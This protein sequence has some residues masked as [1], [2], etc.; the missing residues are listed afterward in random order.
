MISVTL[1]SRADCHL[2]EQALQDLEDLKQEY[3]HRLTVIDVDSDPKLAKEFGFEV[4]VVTVEP[5]RLKAPF[6]VQELKITL[7]AAQDRERHIR[8][9]ESSPKLVELREKG[10]WR[11]SDSI[12]R[13][14]SNHYMLLFNMAVLI[15]LGG[16]FL[17]PLLMK[18]GLETPAGILYKGYSLVCHQL[19]YRSFFLFGKQAIYPRAAAGASGLLTFSQATGLGEGSSISDLFKAR[20]YSGDPGNGYKIALCERDLAIYGGILI[21][22]LL[23]SLTR[24][25]IPSL[26]WYFWVLLAVVPIALDGL[27]QLVSQ[28]PLSFFPF[29]E[30]TAQLR[31]LTGFLFGFGTAWF[32]YPVVE[33]SM[34]EM[35]SIYREKWQRMNSAI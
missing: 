34:K 30:S 33:E 24:Y 10:V 31:V 14:F 27:S 5:F 16:A 11:K 2:C 32:G 15:Y 13:W 18:F 6:T 8:M 21:F 29:R 3:P 19:G 35:R 12:S 28:P 23:F 22:G 1:Y 7:A 4:P 25:R 17:A 9:V 26:P 20:S